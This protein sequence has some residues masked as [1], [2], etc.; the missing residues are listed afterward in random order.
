MDIKLTQADQPGV[1]YL[2]IRDSSKKGVFKPILRTA[3]KKKLLDE[4]AKLL[5]TSSE[6]EIKNA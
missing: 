4:I 3:D 2:E 5:N 1:Y 6:G